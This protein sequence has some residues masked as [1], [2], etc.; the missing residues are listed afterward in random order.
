MNDS[1]G[2]VLP[3]RYSEPLR[4]Y[5]ELVQRADTLGLG[6]AWFTEIAGADAIAMAAASAMPTSHIRLATGIVPIATRTPPLIAMGAATVQQLSEGRAILGLGASTPAILGRW[7]GLDTDAP[8]DRLEETVAAVRAAFAG[9]IAFEG[10]HVQSHGFHLTL[11][12]HAAPPIHVAALGPRAIGLAARVADGALLTLS[13]R[14]H[15][16]HVAAD[17]EDIAGIRPRPRVVAYVRVAIGR[18]HEATR[19]WMRRELAWYGASAAY[20]A[21]FSRQG[22]SGEV[23]ALHQAW[24]RDDRAAAV[25]AITDDMCD[26][27]SITGSP[28]QARAALQALLAAGVDEVA[29]YFVDAEREGV[30]G[31]RG[32]LEALADS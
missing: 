29:C 15:L 21:H 22:F 4:D 26:R 17:L 2:L 20:R 13:T 19:E 3:A 27:L 9:E 10:E 7:H 23:A 5:V 12:P 16:E 32:Q 8:L 31:I 11:A 1:I 30:R 25:A 14:E 24:E 28:G 6:T 18:P